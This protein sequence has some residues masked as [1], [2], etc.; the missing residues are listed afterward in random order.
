MKWQQLAEQ[1]L[2]RKTGKDSCCKERDCIG[3]TNAQVL[4]CGVGF[5][6]L[7]CLKVVTLMPGSMQGCYQ[8]HC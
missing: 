7:V 3:R 2:N 8:R 5:A 4:S 1:I 6:V